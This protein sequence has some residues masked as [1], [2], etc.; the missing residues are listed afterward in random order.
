M[1][2]SPCKKHA[3]EEPLRPL[4]DRHVR[5]SGVFFLS[6]TV[7]VSIVSL[8]IWASTTAFH[9]QSTELAVDR[10]NCECGCW[11]GQ[12]KGYLGAF[13]KKGYKSVYFNYD[14]RTLLLLLLVFCY[15]SF[16]RAMISRIIELFFERKLDFLRFVVLC[17]TVYPNL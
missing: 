11:D 3:D 4:L 7:A 15:C 16:F 6:A 13:Q 9:V 17:F 1:M 2:L 5:A 10:E 8:G 14:S 12:F